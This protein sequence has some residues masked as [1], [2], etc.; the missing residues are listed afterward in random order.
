MV[1]LTGTSTES[2]RRLPVITCDQGGLAHRPS[3][4]FVYVSVYL[5]R[6]DS[7]VTPKVHILMTENVSFYELLMKSKTR[8]G[9][10]HICTFK[11]LALISF[12]YLLWNIY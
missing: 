4:H 3:G 11:S 8:P 7:K 9:F 6:G 12:N 5:P 1:R 10:L 2:D